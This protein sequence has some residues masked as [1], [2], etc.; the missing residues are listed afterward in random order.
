M[1]RSIFLL[2]VI[3]CSLSSYAQYRGAIELGANIMSANFTLNGPVETNSTW[4]IRLGYVGEYSVSKHF[5]FR[6]GLLVNQR[7]FELGEERWGLNALDV[8]LNIGYSIPLNDEGF[9]FF[10]DGGFDLEYNFHAFTKINDELVALSI[11][12]EQDD[13]KS[14]GTGFNIGT[15]LQVSKRVKTRVSYYKGLS[16][17]VRTTNDEWKNKVI[18]VA[19]IYFLN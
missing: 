7:G 12:G 15:G 8:P 14:F 6:F 5:Y 2:L 11:G 1:K 4:G 19:V 3:L 16:N 18:G 9:E 13:I 17:L 10:I